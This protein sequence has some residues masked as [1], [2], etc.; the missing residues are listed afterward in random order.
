MLRHLKSRFQRTDSDFKAF[1]KAHLYV[2]GTDAQIDSVADE[3][4]E[5]PAAVGNLP[6][7]SGL[8]YLLTGFSQGSPFGTGNLS[9]LT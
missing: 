6:N 3:Y 4:S 8:V 5:D 1:L 9:V 7:I 2:G